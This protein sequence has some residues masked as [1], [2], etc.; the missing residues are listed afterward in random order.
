MFREIGYLTLLIVFFSCGDSLKEKDIT[1]ASKGGNAVIDKQKL[2]ER[3]DDFY[4]KDKYLEAISSYDTLIS[5][6]STNGE[7]YFKRGY[8]KS[9][10]LHDAASAISDYFVAIERNY[11]RKASAYL[12]IA[13]L[14]RNDAKYDSA[15]Y[16][17]NECLR[18]DDSNIKAIQG[19][20]EVIE[21]LHK[22]K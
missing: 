18:T 8:S 13:V 7:Y 1:T 14:Y 22:F 4:E 10:L 11:S 15:L 3:A 16:Y 12:N 21:I 5:I 9:M 6:D 17:Y 2:A 19:K 20:K